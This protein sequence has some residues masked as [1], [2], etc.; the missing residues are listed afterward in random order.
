MKRAQIAIAA[1][2]L[3]GLALLAA[4]QPPV[5]VEVPPRDALGV[6]AP[7]IRGP[8][9]DRFFGT[10]CQSG[11]KKF[12]KDVRW[13]PDPCAEVEGMAIHLDHVL[14]RNGSQLVGG[15]AFRL[16]GERALVTVAGAVTAPRT[17][18]F[19]ADVPG[20]GRERGDAWISTDGRK[21]TVNA[22]G[23]SLV[24]SKSLCGNRA[25]R[26][27]L[28]LVGG[29]EFPFRRSI[30]L[31]AAIDDED[32]E[33]PADRIQFVS[34]RQGP[35]AGH[36]A[37]GNRTLHTTRLVPGRHEV[38]VRV[39][40]SGGLTARDSVELTVV[41]RPP[42]A[43]IDQP[44]DGA[45]VPATVPVFLRGIAHDPEEGVLPAGRLRWE[46]ERAPGAGFTPVGGGPRASVTFDQTGP[47]RVRL[48]ATDSAGE[49]HT[50][51]HRL[52]VRPFSGNAPPQVT[53]EQPEMLLPG[54]EFAIITTAG[55]PVR[56]E[57]SAADL[58]DAPQDLDLR[59][60][61][62]ALDASGR[63]D[64]NPRVPNPPAVTGELVTEVTFANVGNVAYRGT[65]TARDSAGAESSASVD[66]FVLAEPVQ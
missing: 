37:N 52:T 25:P 32:E 19:A 13:A 57:A 61:F 50:A 46:A 40:D 12:C 44:D 42:V 36:R 9:D 54:G 53:I 66:V 51:E 29:P 48:T 4:A 38:T 11:K 7:T 21:L 30:T 3:L 16:D 35:I 59:W 1:G 8:V 22:L 23:R 14:T 15:G 62:A 27:S 64:P 65:F 58:E 10:F 26:V 17:A 45:P 24:L 6:G 41:N 43:R 5:T 34:D 63:P 56:W 55:V 2:P 18:R 49:R 60:G 33:F 39:I 47:A 28:N 31:G 20:L